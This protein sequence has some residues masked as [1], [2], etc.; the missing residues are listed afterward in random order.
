MKD[1]LGPVARI[2]IGRSDL[3]TRERYFIFYSVGSHWHLLN[4]NKK[5]EKW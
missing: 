3:Q 1:A 5:E 2:G 4:T